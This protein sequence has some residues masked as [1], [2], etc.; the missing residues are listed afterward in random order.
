MYQCGN[1]ILLDSVDG[2]KNEN[3]NDIKIEIKRSIDKILK[4]YSYRSSLTH[5][6]H[7]HF[8]NRLISFLALKRRKIAAIP[9]IKAP[10]PSASATMLIINSV[11]LGSRIGFWSVPLS[12]VS[13]E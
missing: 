7:N 6:F 13:L 2:T 8:R 5:T 11:D 1:F 4:K 10:D 3:E 12:N 9:M